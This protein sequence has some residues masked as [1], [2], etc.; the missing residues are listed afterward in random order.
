MTGGAGYI[1][2]VLVPV[3]FDHGYDVDV[4]DLLWFGNHL[5]AEVQV[6]PARPVRVQ[7][8]GVLGLR[9]GHLPG[10]A[11]ERPD[12]RVQPSQNFVANGA[13]PAYLAYIAKKAG[14]KRFIYASSCSVYGYTDNQLYNE[15]DPVTCGYPYGISKLQGERG[16]LQLQDDRVFD[17]RLAPGHG[18]RLRPGCGST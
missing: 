1:G 8:S 14:V 10:R 17:D 4:V 7:S 18:L 3:L 12:G 16:V 6:H 9:P 15:D 2:S 13:L 11:V 5:P